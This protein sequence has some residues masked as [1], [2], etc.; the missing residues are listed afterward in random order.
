M[1]P[2]TIPSP[3]PD[4][5]AEVQKRHRDYLVSYIAYRDTIP[6]RVAIQI[7]KDMSS[8][9]LVRLDM[10]CVR[11]DQGPQHSFEYDPMGKANE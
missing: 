5:D 3:A 1:L 9:D 2:N 6:M 4:P 10:E 7:L 8:A 11:R